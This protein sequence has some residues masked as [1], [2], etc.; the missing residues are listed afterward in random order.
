MKADENNDT[1]FMLVFATFL[2][3]VAAPWSLGLLISLCYGGLRTKEGK[4]RKGFLISLTLNILL[5]AVI[6]YITLR[7]QDNE[8]LQDFD[9]YAVLGVSY[10]ANESAIKKAYR[11]LSLEWHPD[12]NSD[13]NAT[14]MFF[15]INKAKE[16]LT[17][18][19]KKENFLKYGNPDGYRTAYTMSV[20]LPSFLFDKSNQLIVLWAFAFVMLVVF[21]CCIYKW[22]SSDRRERDKDTGVLVENLEIYF[23][24]ASKKMKD[25]QIIPMFACSSEFQEQ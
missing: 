22:F 23:G 3:L 5:W 1:A 4:W 9:P 7:L 6:Y 10:D 15:L 13:P 11:R 24:E 19:E 17:D 18:P 20:A 25:A 16:I 12:K 21:P 2:C 14:K 8:W